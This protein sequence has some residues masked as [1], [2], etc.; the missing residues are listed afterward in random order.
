MVPETRTVNVTECRPEVK[1]R[2][3]TYHKPVTETRQVT[4]NIT[5]LVRQQRSR[6]VEYTVCK[7]VWHEVDQQYTVC[8]PHQERRQGI[9]KVCRSVQVQETRT[10]CRDEG[11]WA[12]GTGRRWLAAVVAAIPAEAVVAAVH[13]AC[14]CRKSSPRKYPLRSGKKRPLTSHSSTTSP[15]SRLKVR[16]GKSKSVVS[17]PKNT[18]RNRCIMSVFLRNAREPAT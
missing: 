10:V 2:M 4:D 11:H 13:V 1:Q 8:V 15:F 6:T 7:P 5:V 3:V 16:P 14:G 18:P 9:R 12:K 17:S